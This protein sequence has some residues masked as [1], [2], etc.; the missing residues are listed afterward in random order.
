MEQVAK[1][2]RFPKENGGIF[3]VKFEEDDR[4]ERKVHRMDGQADVRVI[5]PPKDA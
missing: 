5:E 3:A 2:R 4:P 1:C